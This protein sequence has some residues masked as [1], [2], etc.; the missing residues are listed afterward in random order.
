MLVKIEARIRIF[1][2]TDFHF[3][4][5][6]VRPGT[7]LG[8]DSAPSSVSFVSSFSSRVNKARLWREQY[9]LPVCLSVCLSVCP[10]RRFSVIL[11]ARRCAG[12]VYAMARCHTPVLYL[13]GWMDRT[14][15][16]HRGYL[17]LLLQRNS[18]R[19][20]WKTR[21]FFWNFV[22]K[23]GLSNISQRH[24]NRRKCCQLSATDD[25]RQFITLSVHMW[26]CDLCTTLWALHG[27][28]CDGWDQ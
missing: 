26:L 13:H 22:P 5:T 23:S 4:S 6:S 21:V 14:S 19:P 15:Y 25:R 10:F 18:G 20:I 27:L 28:V 24:V 2:G 3:P 16:R 9:S 8:S 11:P 17:R 1:P 7:F 12:S